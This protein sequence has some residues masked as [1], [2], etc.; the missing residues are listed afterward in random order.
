MNFG[1]CHAAVDGFFVSFRGTERIPDPEGSQ[2]IQTSSLSVNGP[3]LAALVICSILSCIPR[4]VCC[5][6]SERWKALETGQEAPEPEPFDDIKLEHGAYHWQRALEHCTGSV[7]LS[8][9]YTYTRTASA[10]AQI[11]RQSHTHTT[12]THTHAFT[13]V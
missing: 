1:V 12:H 8:D 9:P 3:A 7:G 10:Q 11:H 6:D 2:N 4:P 13:N 5:L